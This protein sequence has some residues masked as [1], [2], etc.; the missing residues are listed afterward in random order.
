V[1]EDEIPLAGGLSDQ[2]TALQEAGPP[3]P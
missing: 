3:L 1:V 2:V